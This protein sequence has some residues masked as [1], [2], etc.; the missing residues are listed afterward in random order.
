[1]TRK[2][3]L[4][5][6]FYVVGVFASLGGVVWSAVVIGVSGLCDT[7]CPSDA[8]VARSTIVFPV[9]LA[10]LLALLA[11]A[12]VALVRRRRHAK[13]GERGVGP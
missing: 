8:A 11:Y 9:S 1:M 6:G 5:A 2:P 3:Y 4:L 13:G 7:N 12:V 10:V